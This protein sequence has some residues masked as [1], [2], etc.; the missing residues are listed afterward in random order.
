MGINVSRILYNLYNIKLSLVILNKSYYSNQEKQEY[1]AAV[2]CVTKRLNWCALKRSIFKKVYDYFQSSGH[3]E[4]L[5]HPSKSVSNRNPVM[6]V[7][8]CWTLSNIA[9]ISTSFWSVYTI[10]SHDHIL[11][12]RSQ[13]NKQKHDHTRNDFHV[14][15]YFIML[16]AE[17]A[18]VNSRNLSV[19]TMGH[20]VKKMCSCEQTINEI[21][22]SHVGVAWKLARENERIVCTRKKKTTY[23]KWTVW[24]SRYINE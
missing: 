13:V 8:Y 11:I 12:T 9:F 6:W 18:C 21:K 16:R 3:F 2:Y 17:I 23:N 24:R 19:N 7:F 15:V 22:E 1:F 20:H 10:M 4:K 14:N 5:D